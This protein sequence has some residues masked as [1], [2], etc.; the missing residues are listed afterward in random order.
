M[1]LNLWQQSLSA[2]TIA[3][4]TAPFMLPSSAQAQLTGQLRCA[5]Q[6]TAIFAERSAASAVVR[7]VSENQQ[8][9]IAENTAQN[10]FLAVST[11]VRGFVQTV[12][13]RVCPGRPEPEKPPTTPA[14][15]CRRVTQP[16]GLIIR[17]SPNVSSPVVGGANFNTQVNVS[18]TPTTS[19][20]DSTGRVWV[21]LSKPAAG[22]VS[23]GFV[24]V[25]GSNLVNCQ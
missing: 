4:L 15:T 11:P 17:Q 7:S 8:M 5:K 23:N 16:Q 10:G 1:K 13:L 24:K 12:T 2:L 14:S 3:G 21:Q 19:Q 25:P 6:S 20:V 18:T 9:T 22:W